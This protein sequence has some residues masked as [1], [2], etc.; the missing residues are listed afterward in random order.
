MESVPSSPQRK[1][2]RPAEAAAFLRIGVSTFWLWVRTRPDFPPVFKVGQ[3]VSLVDADALVVW[4]NS[5]TKRSKGRGA[6]TGPV[7][8]SDVGQASKNECASA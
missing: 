7:L 4:R 1:S 6:K 5:K 3:G 8:S 2:L